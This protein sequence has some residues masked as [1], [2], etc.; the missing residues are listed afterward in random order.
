MLTQEPSQDIRLMKSSIFLTQKPRIS[1]CPPR[2]MTDRISQ[3][4][5]VKDWAS[6]GTAMHSHS[7]DATQVLQEPTTQSQEEDMIVI[8]LQ[9]N[10]EK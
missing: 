4:L 2:N 8:D 5:Q 9:D 1:L 7:P 6:N 3:S 10:A